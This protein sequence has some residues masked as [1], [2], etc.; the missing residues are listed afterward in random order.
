MAEEGID[1]SEHRRKLVTKEM[2]DEA[3]VVICMAEPNTVPDFVKE[4]L[5]FIEWQ[6]DDPKGT[7]FETHRKIKNQIKAGIIETFGK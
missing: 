6:I 2:I 3:D 7:D 1:V 4:H 5:G